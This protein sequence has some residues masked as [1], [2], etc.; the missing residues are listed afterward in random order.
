MVRTLQRDLPLK[1][2]D[3]RCGLGQPSKAGRIPVT[4]TP[5]LSVCL[6]TH[7]PDPAILGQV[8]ESL[9]AQV[10]DREL[11][12]LILVDNASEPPMASRVDLSPWSHAK[13]LGE[14]RLGL[15]WA[16]G[17]A[18]EE[19][20][21]EILIFVDDD[22][23]L[24]KYYLAAA[25]EAMHRHPEVGVAGGA[26]CGRFEKPPPNWTQRFLPSLAVRD[27]GVE[28]IIDIFPLRH[29]KWFPC[30]AGMV[31]RR[32]LATQWFQEVVAG[33]EPGRLGRMGE[34][35]SSGEDLAL[36]CHVLESGL[37][38][39]YFPQLRLDHV[40][41]PR[42]LTVSYLARLARQSCR[43]NLPLL[44]AHGLRRMLRP[45]PLEY[46]AAIVSCVQCGQWHPLT[47][48][49]ALQGAQGYYAASRDRAR[50]NH[51]LAQDSPV[52]ER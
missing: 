31:V 20:R 8:L 1:R 12:E 34:E 43:S 30:G 51:P 9:R 50:R 10:L 15:L 41:P 24:S 14:P 48:W 38:L 33:P 35:L 4:K 11:W 45:W 32:T 28:S 29:R 18:I 22:N 5:R 17:R 21:G 25:L 37:A 7:N 13:V 39:A 40:I 26:N 47:W 19:A 16:R 52:M 23:I 46:L 49:V 27:C 44:L 36:V 6:C 3:T 42:R 2:S